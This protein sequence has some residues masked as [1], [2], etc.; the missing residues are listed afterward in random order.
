MKLNQNVQWLMLGSMFSLFSSALWYCW[1]RCYSGLRSCVFQFVAHKFDLAEHKFGTNN[2]VV[3]TRLLKQIGL[4]TKRYV[5]QHDANAETGDSMMVGMIRLPTRSW[6]MWSLALLE[7]THYIYISDDGRELI[8]IGP[9]EVKESLL[10]L[11]N[12]SANRK[13]TESELQQLQEQL[14]DKHAFEWPFVCLE[15]V[16]GVLC[17]GIFV[18]FTNALHSNVMSAVAFVWLCFIM[19]HPAKASFRRLQMMATSSNRWRRFRANRNVPVN[20]DARALLPTSMPLASTED[21]RDQS[22]YVSLVEMSTTTPNTTTPNDGDIKYA[23]VIARQQWFEISIQRNTFPSTPDIEVPDETKPVIYAVPMADA[24]PVLI[25][26]R[27]S[28][29]GCSLYICV[30]NPLN[31]VP[32]VEMRELVDKADRN[33]MLIVILPEAELLDMALMDPNSSITRLHG[34]KETRYLN[35]HADWHHWL[36]EL[37]SGVF[38]R[39]AVI[40]PYSSQEQLQKTMLWKTVCR[41]GLPHSILFEQ[42]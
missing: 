31:Q 17:V 16:L 11:A 14:F 34:H 28:S 3:I 35:V 13:A 32:V 18:Y 21:N 37:A 19:Y 38:T 20:A 41:T 40:L 24:L 15:R 30:H 22:D 33:I 42:P 26:A 2:I 6:F 10:R 7:I 23:V 1:H 9:C 8:F 27:V 4:D 12:V 5:W 39:L 29:A 25:A 36:N